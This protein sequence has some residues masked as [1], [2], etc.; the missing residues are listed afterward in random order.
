VPI[1]SLAYPFLIYKVG[2]RGGEKEIDTGY[3][4]TPQPNNHSGCW[5]SSGIAPQRLPSKLEKDE[6]KEIPR[7]GAGEKE[8]RV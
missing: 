3:S 4:P 1:T 5:I 7:I 2:L 6:S 8:G